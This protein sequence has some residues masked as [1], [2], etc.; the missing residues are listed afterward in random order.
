MAFTVTGAGITAQVSVG[1]ARRG[2]VYDVT[3]AKDVLMP[4]AARPIRENSLR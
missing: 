2:I 1:N 4:N 3:A